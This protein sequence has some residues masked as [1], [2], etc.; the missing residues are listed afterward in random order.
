LQ[1]NSNDE[2]GFMVRIFRRIMD[3][4]GCVIIALHHTGKAAAA[5]M[6]S[7][8]AYAS[9]GATALVDASRQTSQ[10]R[11]VM[12]EEA[13][14]FGLTDDDRRDIF[15]EDNGKASLTRAEN[16][17]Y[18]RKVPVRLGNGTSER[19]DGTTLRA[20]ETW[21]PPDVAHA[22]VTDAEINDVQEA[23][24]GAAPDVRRASP[25]SPGWVGYLIDEALNLGIDPHGTKAP[26]RTPEQILARHR[27]GII[28]NTGLFTGWLVQ[29]GEKGQ[30]RKSHSC[31]S[32]GAAP[33]K[34]AA[35]D[36]P[37]PAGG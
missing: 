25:R 22:D 30:D 31:V 2:M 14:R 23:L 32:P 24:A 18:W 9:R 20:V 7:T 27:A 12:N 37:S 34:P 16:V 26:D 28:L 6:K 21:T 17:R 1:E 3:E 10:V 8:G 19:P 13:K 36:C 15:A 33:D 5:D 4:T 11:G 35:E 29:G